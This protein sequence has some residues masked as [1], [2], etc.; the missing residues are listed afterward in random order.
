MVEAVTRD[1]QKASAPDTAAAS[2]FSVQPSSEKFQDSREEN[3]AS[4]NVEVRQPEVASR[5]P[6]AGSPESQ[7]A[8]VTMAAATQAVADANSGPRWTA[9]PVTLASDE[10]SMSLE[11]EMQK[12]YAAYAAADYATSAGT[13]SAESAADNSSSSLETKPEPQAEAV[14]ESHAEAVSETAGPTVETTP[15]IAQV[16][17]TAANGNASS[18]A[19]PAAESHAAAP[20]AEAAS[21]PVAE[22]A[23]APAN[24]SPAVDYAR[25]TEASAD[26]DSDTHASKFDLDTV[27]TTAAAWA[28]WSQ[29]RDT[30]KNEAEP[31]SF[32]LP[33]EPLT[34]EPVSPSIPQ[35][36]TAALAVAAGAEQ[37]AQEAVSTAPSDHPTDVASIVDSVLAGLRPKLM[38][39]ITRKMAEKK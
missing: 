19:E 30:G 17:E 27:K 37:T 3:Q 29:V 11:H 2:E 35:Q 7:D 21:A 33:S 13:T 38:E 15:E 25:S 5:E 6:E 9:V 1:E 26:V 10:T 14:S 8:P 22:S 20:V 39:E 28:S 18:F 16:A 31:A 4:S 12:A 23:S 34:P 32:E 36:D 24:E